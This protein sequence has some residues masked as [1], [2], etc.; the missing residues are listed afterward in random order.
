MLERRG[1]E[2]AFSGAELPLDFGPFEI[3]T[4][5]VRFAPR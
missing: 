1:R 5:R 2:L 3:K 4:L